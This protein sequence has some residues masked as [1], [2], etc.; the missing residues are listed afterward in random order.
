MMP[1]PHDAADRIDQ[2]FAQRSQAES[3]E[4]RERFSIKYP[5]SI[6]S[7]VC[8]TLVGLLTLCIPFSL[9]AQKPQGEWIIVPNEITTEV[10]R[11]I[12][13]DIERAMKRNVTTIVLQFQS[14]ELSNFGDCWD[15]A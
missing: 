2:T 3:S 1:N 9:L 4:R 7:L 12:R 8:G 5:R 15:L 11:S 13:N 10:G 6:G 14:R